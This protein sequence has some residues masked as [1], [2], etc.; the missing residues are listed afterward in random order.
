[1][2]SGMLSVV[3]HELKTPLTSIR[4]GVHLLLEER[5]G[6]LTSE[7]ND[8]LVALREDSD[9]L[10]QIVE[11]LLDMGRIESGRAL[12]DLKSEPAAGLVSDAVEAASA[13]FHDRGVELV[14]EVPEET[15]PV[16]A[17]RHRI[18]H[19]FSNLLNNA[20]RYTPPGGRV[21]VRATATDDG[22]KFSVEDTGS[23]IPE[24]FQNR[25]FE[26]FFRVPGQTS[27][28]GAGLGLAITKDIVEAH[29]GHVTVTSREGKG[30]T[31]SFELQRADTADRRGA[32][33]R[34]A[35]RSGA[36]RNGQEVTHEVAVHSDR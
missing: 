23:G 11:N 30:S 29:G 22:V 6:S 25:I 32:D 21:T 8:I 3:S 24:Q 9:R 33:R 31:F 35:D 28:T 7:Q 2:K 19:V 4:M 20:L 34:G 13:A 10:N 15:P 26:R 5:I 17:D 27:A 12:L 16:L 18:S 36:D 1:M 14:S